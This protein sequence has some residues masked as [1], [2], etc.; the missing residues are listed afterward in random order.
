[1]PATH[2]QSAK[3]KILEAALS[4]IRTKGYAATTVDDLCASP[5]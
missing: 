5:A 2:K 4:V 1:M 3:D